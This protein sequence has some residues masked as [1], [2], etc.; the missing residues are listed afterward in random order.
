MILGHLTGVAARSRADTPLSAI[1]KEPEI[2]TVPTAT[3]AEIRNSCF[4]G[5]K[6]AAYNNELASRMIVRLT[7]GLIAPLYQ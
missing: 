7:L 1:I 4:C 6:G 5:I 3:F 2:V